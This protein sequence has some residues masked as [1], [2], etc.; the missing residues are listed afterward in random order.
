MKTDILTPRHEWPWE[1][2]KDRQAEVAR[3]MREE[4]VSEDE[5][6]DMLRLRDKALDKVIKH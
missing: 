5:A 2:R 6:K 1:T 3:L 4:N